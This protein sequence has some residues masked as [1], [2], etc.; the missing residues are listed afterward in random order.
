MF[1]TFIRHRSEH[2]VDTILETFIYPEYL[3][4]LKCFPHSYH[5]VDREGRPILI[6]RMGR[7]DTEQLFQ[8]TSS[9]RILNYMRYFRE[10]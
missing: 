7:I 3:K 10:H 2:N 9:E 6:E 5:G 4:V 8:I 1:D